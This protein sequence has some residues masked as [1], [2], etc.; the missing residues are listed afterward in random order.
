MRFQ[1]ESL[2]DFFH[3]GGHAPYVWGAW[4]LA[5]AIIIGLT[6]RA[7]LVE[8]EWKRRLQQLE[9]QQNRDQP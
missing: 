9:D 8:S 5:A 7:C 2:T 4:A 6:V 3:M 1:F